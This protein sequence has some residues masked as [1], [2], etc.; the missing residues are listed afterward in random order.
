MTQLAPKPLDERLYT[1]NDSPSDEDQSFVQ[2]ESGIEDPKLLKEH[3][4]A[5]QRKAYAVCL[6][7]L[8]LFSEGSFIFCLSSMPTRVFGSLCS[9]GSSYLPSRTSIYG[10]VHYR[11]KISTFTAYEQVLELGREREGAILLDIGCCCG[12]DI[13]KVARDGFPIENLIASDL[14]P[15][16]WHIGHELFRSTPET[17][18]VTFLAGDVFDS[19][20]LEPAAPAIHPSDISLSVPLLS[21]LSS[22]TPLHGKISVIHISLVFHLFLEVQQLQLARALGGLLSP[23]PGS[24][25]LGCH[26]GQQWKGFRE[27]RVGDSGRLMFCHSPD[28]WRE[29]W[30]EVF[31]R[32]AVN[33]QAE[34]KSRVTD[35]PGSGMLTWSVT[36]V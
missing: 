36:R 11:P 10:A 24:V 25:I 15:D 5:I 17:F 7:L 8:S 13:R 35:M 2:S 26:V 12:T 16:F 22:L 31:P 23:L 6:F 30:E 32:G 18:P 19:N 9:Q 28:S 33:V 21:S 3:V 4:V 29:M 27:G 1:V 34:L 14:R 20:F